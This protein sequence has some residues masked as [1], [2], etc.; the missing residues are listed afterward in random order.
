MIHNSSKLGN[1]PIIAAVRGGKNEFSNVQ[2][3]HSKKYETNQIFT[4]K[5][6][7]QNK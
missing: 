1:S 3:V 7:K 6:T 5:L 2:I 4:K